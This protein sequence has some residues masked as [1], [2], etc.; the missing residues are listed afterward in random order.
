MNKVEQIKKLVIE[1]NQYRD[2]Y[3]NHSTSPVSDYVYDSKFDELKQLEQETGIVFANS[4]TQTVGFE[5][6]SSLEKVVHSH[7]MLSLDKTKSVKELVAFLKNKMGIMMLKMD[8]LTVS[9]HYENG[10]LVSAETR[11]NG[12]IGENIFHNAKVFEN[13]PLH[14]AFKGKLTVDGEA[15]I[16]Y[17]DFFAINEQIENPDEKYKN[18][19]NLV[20]GSVRQLDSQIAKSRHIKFVAWKLVDCSYEYEPSFRIQLSALATLGFTVVPYVSVAANN[21]AQMMEEIIEYLKNEADKNKYPID[22][23]VLGYDDIAYGNSLGATGH[24]LRSQIAYKFYDEEVETNLVDVDWTMGKTGTLTPTAI[25]E[26]VEISGS[27]IERASLHNVSILKEL[28]LHYGD[29]VTVYK[30]NDVIP[31]IRDNLSKTEHDRNSIHVEIPNVCPICGAKTE[32]VQDSDTAVL[33]CTNPDCKGKLLG[34]LSHFVSKNAMNIDGLSEATLEK[35]IEKGWLTSFSDI[36]TVMDVHYKEIVD[37]N[38]FGKKSADKLLTSINDSL[39][40]TLDRFIYALCIPM[41]GRTAS[42]TISKYFDGD[43]ERFY[44]EGLTGSFD[45]TIL[46]DFGDAMSS[47]LNL[48]AANSNMQI[49]LDLGHKMNFQKPTVSNDANATNLSGMTFVITGSLNTFTNRD[50]AKEKIESLGGKVAGSVSKNTTYLVN[51]DINSTSG[52]NKKAKDL[53]I[54]IITEEELLNILRN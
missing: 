50:E 9:L 27:T 2:A 32:I 44:H 1:L 5:V 35:F 21:N 37:M 10:E 49:L 54:P 40:A 51:N 48:Y 26:P 7:P 3:Y 14:I 34:K 8:G 6:K 11:G 29:T 43:F 23:M 20:S 19:R 42:K 36:Y 31:Q 30:A 28:D 13:I 53:G 17:D 45:W 24:H 22:G 4:P 33:T 39:N 46:D 25:F 47:S 38:G 16:T 12:E 41:I 15:I 52:K 18:P